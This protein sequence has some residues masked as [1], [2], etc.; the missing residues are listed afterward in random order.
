MVLEPICSTEST[1]SLSL[2]GRFELST[3]VFHYHFSSFFYFGVSTGGIFQQNISVICAPFSSWISSCENIVITTLP[4]CEPKNWLRTW[5]HRHPGS[6]PKRERAV[7]LGFMARRWGNI[8]CKK[9]EW[10]LMH[11]CSFL[12]DN[13]F[14]KLWSCF[15]EQG[16][17]LLTKNPNC[18]KTFR[19]AVW[20]VSL[21]W[22]HVSRPW[23][24]GYLNWD[25]QAATSHTVSPFGHAI[26]NSFYGWQAA[27]HEFRILLDSCRIVW[28]TFT[29]TH[30][31]AKT[32][33]EKSFMVGLCKCSNVFLQLQRFFLFWLGIATSKRPRE[34]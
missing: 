6:S 25:Q 2:T 12:I 11:I 30:T 26:G 34:V 28:I 7:N 8:R 4:I 16:A 1:T 19:E 9:C 5:H 10:N 22:D 27:C 14:W 15:F 17:H 31:D 29:H 18:S 20:S 13:L 23:P 3:Q 32:G 33:P 24:C 21:L